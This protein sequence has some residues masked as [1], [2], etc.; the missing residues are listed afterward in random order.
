MANKTFQVADY[1]VFI[2]TLVVSTG[3]GLFFAIKDRRK[4]STT[5]FLLGGRTMPL[6][7]VTLSLLASFLSSV[8]VLGIP[9]EIFYNGTLYSLIIFAFAIAYPVSVH[10]F[11]PVFYRLGV[12]SVYE[13]R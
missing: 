6:V 7:P 2:L 11:L 12:T 9:T 5:D 3:I 10:L 8:S 13:V 4:Q 1:V